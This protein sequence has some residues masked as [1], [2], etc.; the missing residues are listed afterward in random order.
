MLIMSTYTFINISI[1]MIFLSNIF[2]N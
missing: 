1:I 2:I